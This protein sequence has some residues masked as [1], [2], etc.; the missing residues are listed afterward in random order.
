MNSFQAPIKPR[1][2]VR[3]TWRWLGASARKFTNKVKV[4]V[5]GRPI[6]PSGS[7]EH[8]YHLTSSDNE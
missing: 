5:R 6:D 4:I 1:F 7:K 8:K 2:D 3:K